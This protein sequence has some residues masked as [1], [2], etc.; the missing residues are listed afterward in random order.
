MPAASDCLHTLQDELSLANL[1]WRETA[2][3]KGRKNTAIA[4]VN[5]KAAENKRKIIITD[6]TEAAAVG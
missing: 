6:A 3:E 2:P 1:L 4:T 5:K